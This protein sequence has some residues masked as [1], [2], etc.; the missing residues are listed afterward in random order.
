[1]L[2]RIRVTFLSAVLR[3]L[4]RSELDRA[5]QIFPAPSDADVAAAAHRLIT[6]LVV[7]APWRIHTWLSSLDFLLLDTKLVHIVV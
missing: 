5:Q 2:G 4:F 6:L 3:T 7:R 1:M